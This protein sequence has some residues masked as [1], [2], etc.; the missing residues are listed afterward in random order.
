MRNKSLSLKTEVVMN[1]E[2]K[3][4]K[5]TMKLENKFYWYRKYKMDGNNIQTLSPQYDFTFQRTR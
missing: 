2:K 4:R 3:Q 1:E 5:S